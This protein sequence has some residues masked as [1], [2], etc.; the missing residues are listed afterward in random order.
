MFKSFANG[1]GFV[2]PAELEKNL[3]P[4]TRAKIEEKLD[5]GWKFDK[6]KWKASVA[7]HARWDMSKVFKQFDAD[8]DGELDIHEFARAFRALGLPKRGG[9]KMDVDREMFESFDSNKNGKVSLP[10]IEENLKPKTRKKIEEKLDGGWKFDRA[11][12]EASVARHARWNMEKVFM[13]FDHDGDG[14][15]SIS[16]LAR[17]FRALGL[18]KRSGAKLDVDKEMF[19]S[20]DTNQ[21]GFCSPAELE[22]N[23]KPKT[24]KKIEEKLDGGWKFDVEKWKASA[25]RHARWDM[26]KVFKQF[27]TDGDGQMNSAWDRS[28]NPRAPCP[29]AAL[30]PPP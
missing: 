29:F 7:R 10:E 11:R 30:N 19:D 25:E 23:L 6:E 26:A 21:D 2:S 17:A 27:D 4:K 24:R 3:L 8:G 20:F 28:S 18:E 15:L 12:W 13:Q 9:A 14:K 5:A 1:D 22:Q 16:E